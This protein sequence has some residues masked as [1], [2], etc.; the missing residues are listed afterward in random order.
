MV[1]K[2]Q[3]S[4]LLLVVVFID[5]NFEFI[6][7]TEFKKP[8]LGSFEPFWFTKFPSFLPNL[9]LTNYHFIAYFLSKNGL[10]VPIS[11]PTSSLLSIA[12]ILP[13]SQQVSSG[14]RIVSRNYLYILTILDLDLMKM[15]SLDCKLLLLKGVLSVIS[16]RL[17]SLLWSLFKTFFRLRTLTLLTKKSKSRRKWDSLHCVLSENIFRIDT[18]HRLGFVLVNRLFLNV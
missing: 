18:S 13:P 14:N 1:I 15:Y 8:S 3:N 10:H 16:S 17:S 7:S 5:L 2:W 4:L 9:F 6:P 11:R 12:P